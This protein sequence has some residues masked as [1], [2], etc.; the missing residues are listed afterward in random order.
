[1][2]RNDPRGMDKQLIERELCSLPVSQYA[3]LSPEEIV[4]S[5]RVRY[6]CKTECPMYGKSWACPPGVGTVDECRGRCLSYEGCLLFTTVTEVNDAA[7]M[8][9]TLA[10]RAPHEEI[11]RAVTKLFKDSGLETMT[12]SAQACCVCEH[13]AYPDAPCRFPEKMFPCVESHGILTTALAENHG[14][15]FLQGNIVTWFTLIFYR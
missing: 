4:F 11:S 15:E 8:E 2:K 5:E 6:I 3:W 14:I 13:C 1:M 12:L 7:D 10:T 9:E